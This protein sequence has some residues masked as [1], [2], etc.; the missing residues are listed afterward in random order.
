MSAY[1][2]ELVEQLYPRGN[3]A[4]SLLPPDLNHKFRLGLPTINVL[5]SVLAAQATTSLPEYPKKDKVRLLE[6]YEN[7]QNTKGLRRGKSR[8]KGVPYVKPAAENF[9]PYPET[10][11]TT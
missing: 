4:Q 5:T 11:M 6:A 10:L 7:H 1:G 3:A 8:T 9:D 2:W